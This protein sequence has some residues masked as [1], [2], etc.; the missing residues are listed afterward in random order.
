MLENQA[1]LIVIGEAKVLVLVHG[2]SVMTFIFM[3]AN[4]ETHSIAWSIIFISCVST[5]LFTDFFK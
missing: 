2:D 4:A 3:L 5:Q 1:T